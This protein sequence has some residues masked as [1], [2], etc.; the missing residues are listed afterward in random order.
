MFDIRAWGYMCARTLI[1]VPLI[2]VVTCSVL[3]TL[4]ETVVSVV[5]HIWTQ[6]SPIAPLTFGGKT[7]PYFDQ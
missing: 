6:D 2:V 1:I 3:W 5:D 7:G 4:L